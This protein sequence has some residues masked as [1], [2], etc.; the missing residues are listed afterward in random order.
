MNSYNFIHKYDM[1]NE[2]NN[3]YKEIFDNLDEELKNDLSLIEKK[4]PSRRRIIDINDDEE[5]D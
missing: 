4:C 2:I 1:L 5:Y 3:Y